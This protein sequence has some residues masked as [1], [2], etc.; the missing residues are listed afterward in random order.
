MGKLKGINDFDL[1]N[2]I[3][4]D[5]SFKITLRFNNFKNALDAIKILSRVVDADKNLQLIANFF[6]PYPNYYDGKLASKFETCVKGKFEGLDDIVEVDSNYAVQQ[7][8]RIIKNQQEVAEVAQ[9]K[10]AS[11][12]PTRKKTRSTNP[13]KV[14]S[15]IVDNLG[16]L[17]NESMTEEN[18]SSLYSEPEEEMP[19]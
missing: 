9:I 1:N 8:E 15:V 10:A 18:N 14:K 6:S 7:L 2:I 12:T 19:L 3:V 17:N 16:K 11:A 13:K 4:K 5:E